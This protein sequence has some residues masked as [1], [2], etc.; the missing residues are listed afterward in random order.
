[1]ELATSIDHLVNSILLKAENQHEF[2]IGACQ[3]EWRLTST[4]EHILMLLTEESLTNSDLAKC[5]SISQAA[6]TKAV[7]GLIGQGLLESQKASGDARS[8]QYLLT[9]QALFIAQE[10]AN[11]HHQTLLAYQEIID[12]FSQSEQEVLSRFM[13][14]LVLRLEKSS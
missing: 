12:K 11:H 5:L 4:Q 14:A 6:V 1:M 2:L 9:E 8:N 10:H 7:K 3:S 13:E